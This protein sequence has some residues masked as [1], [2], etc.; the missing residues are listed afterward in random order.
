MKKL[1]QKNENKNEH[2]GVWAA[3]FVYFIWGFTFLASKTAQKY[4][5]PFVLLA[6]RFDVAAL[7]LAIPVILGRQK[8]NLKNPGKVL[9][10]GMLEP[11]LYFVGEQYGVRLTN[12][13]FSGVM[14][15]MIPIVTLLLAFIFLKERPSIAQWLY[16]LLSI[17]GIVVITVMENRGGAVNFFGVLGLIIA[18][19]T[20]ALYTVLNRKIAT[21]YSVYERTFIAQLL[22]AVF[23]TVPAVIES[24]GNP[25]ALIAPLGHADF[26][27]AVLYLAVF[28]TVLGYTFF[29]YAISNTPTAKVVIMCNMTTVISVLAGV[30]ILG[31]SF[32]PVSAVA[33]IAVLIGIYGVQK[34]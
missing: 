14:I 32:S 7:I 27:I 15:A 6:Y 31:E 16:S 22:G 9:A 13:A 34:T 2:L 21:D 20:G 8:L 1:L 11:C 23:F 25:M 30:F 28:A 24:R 3:F 33:M 17:A 10:L 12:S 19:A 29:N 26:I 5:S 18:V 4:A